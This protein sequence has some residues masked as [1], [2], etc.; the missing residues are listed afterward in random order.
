MSDRR[1]RPPLHALSLGAAL[2]LGTVWVLGCQLHGVLT[3]GW[4]ASTVV[5]FLMILLE[6]IFLTY[7]AFYLIAAL[8]YRAPSSRSLPSTLPAG[9][10]DIAVAYLCCDDLDAEALHSIVTSFGE[11]GCPIVV[12]DDSM[13]GVGRA[14]VDALVGHLRRL[15]TCEIT[16]LRRAD[17]SGGKP[18]AVNH[19][20]GSLPV[21]VA[22]LVLA[23]SDSFFFGP[24]LLMRSLPL[25][26]DPAVA[27]VQARNVGFVHQGAGLGYK[28]LSLAVGCYD[29]FV[30]FC[31]RF[32]WSQFLGHN[33]VVRVSALH[34]V[35][36]C[37]PGQLADDI[38]LSIKLRLA[39]FTI[40]YARDVVCGERHPLT[41][42]ALRRRTAKWAYG[43]TQVLRRWVLAIVLSR[44]LT[45]AEKLTFLLTVN[46]YNLQVLLLVYFIA[47][48]TTLLFPGSSLSC[49]S[50]FVGGSLI[51]V[52]TFAP[53]L[54]YLAAERKLGEW[55]RA[56]LVWA[57]TYGSQDLVIL[58]AVARCLFGRPLDW[59]P[60]NSRVR[61][62][63]FDAL[64]EFWL[65]TALVGVTASL[66]S[67]GLALAAA[68]ALGGKFLIAPLLNRWIFHSCPK[69]SARGLVSSRLAAP[70]SRARDAA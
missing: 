10:T 37:T 48:F 26:A 33:A 69:G 21:H 15:S 17:R 45:L 20:I 56:A 35:G 51:M 68:V 43:C 39:G 6:I 42:E 47:W 36:G 24:E 34:A 7:A 22:Y 55:P 63:S 65:A 4:G 59:V 2:I 41:S 32:G 31:D 25:F 3:E 44:A 12:H 29:L 23:D 54:A 57:L 52:I 13:P 49:R 28:I 64:L 46:Y 40:R 60:T 16:V 38:D 5:H 61:L 70:E 19:V 58:K 9:R 14:A 62:G 18:G 50:A 8:S 53:S 1:P 11:V 67:A 30:Y 27:V 66:L